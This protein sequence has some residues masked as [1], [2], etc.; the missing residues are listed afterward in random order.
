M[1][2]TIT[3]RSNQPIDIAD[4]RNCHRRPVSCRSAIWF[5]EGPAQGII[6]TASDLSMTGFSIR[7]LP[8]TLK[9]LTADAAMY[10]VLLIQGAHI[11]CLVK[12]KSVIPLADGCAKVGF[13]FEALSQN[14]RRLL[15]GVLHFLE[16]RADEDA[17]PRCP[18]A[19]E[20]ECLPTRCVQHD[21]IEWA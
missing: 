6:G 10:C 2:A 18:Q 21:R 9:P 15:S 20:S 13:C 8:S 19:P 7:S 14:N 1:N 4:R 3:E 11:D 17:A 12:I 5:D 16:D